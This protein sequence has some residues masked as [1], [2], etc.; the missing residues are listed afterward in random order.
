MQ[1]RETI[2]AFSDVHLGLKDSNSDDILEFLQQLQNRSDLSDLVIVGDFIDLWRRDVI[3]LEFEIS[4]YIE[5]LKA[6][7][8]KGVDVHYIIGNHDFHIGC[9]KNYAYP[10]FEF[11][12]SLPLERF[13]YKIN[14]LHGHQCDSLQIIL[15]PDG[16]EIFCWTLSDVAGDDK[17]KLWDILTKLLN[18]FKLSPRLGVNKDTFNTQFEAL[19][20]PPENAVRK[21]A[22]E[23][24][25]KTDSEVISC[26]RKNLGMGK[27]ENEFIV[28]GHTHK[29]F[30]D[31]NE[32][33]ANTGC[34]IKGTPN[35]Y[36]EFK[37]WPPQVIP[38]EVKPLKSLKSMGISTRKLNIA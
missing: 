22:Y 30:I 8:N 5:A 26:L 15:G 17:S 24:N 27:G 35:T 18:F 21:E 20:S 12:T 16:M 32:R 7:Q 31:I 37:K 38:F 14:F 29:P 4:E 9:L 19:M 36:F 25:Y 10:N 13:G 3:G 11:K 28:F 23:K 6:I 34:W 33:V 1:S 2:I